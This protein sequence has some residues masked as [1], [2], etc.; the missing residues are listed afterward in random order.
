MNVLLSIKPAFAFEIF[1]GTK[2]FEYRR[3]IFREPVGRV[4]VYASSPVK[5]VVGEFSIMDILFEDLH[6][7]WCR[8]KQHSGISRSY[9]YLYFSNKEKGYAIKIG[10]IIRYKTPHLLQ[11]LYGIK[12]PQSFAY[13][14]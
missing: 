1:R 11:D 8:T 6:S 3:T 9:F 10:K 4:V 13:I 7:L 5:K 14:D 2:K 12:P